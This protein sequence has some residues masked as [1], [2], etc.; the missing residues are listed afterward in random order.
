MRISNTQWST[1]IGRTELM[2]TGLPNTSVIDDISREK[3]TQH[4]LSRASEPSS[5]TLYRKVV[6]SVAV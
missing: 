1:K 5:T 3:M 4:G 6:D 2:L